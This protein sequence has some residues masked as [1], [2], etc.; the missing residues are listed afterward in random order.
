MQ[1]AEKWRRSG[2]AFGTV[3]TVGDFIGT[4]RVQDQVRCAASN[5]LKVSL[6]QTLG[7]LDSRTSLLSSI[8]ASLQASGSDLSML[9]QKPYSLNFSCAKHA[10][11][12]RIYTHRNVHFYVAIE[13]L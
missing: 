12:Q 8:V 11:S 1:K 10:S 3:L 9:W 2:S 13:L 5:S 4:A 7:R 6:S